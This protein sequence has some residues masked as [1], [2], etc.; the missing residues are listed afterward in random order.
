[1][2]EKLTSLEDIIT[3]NKQE[4]ENEEQINNISYNEFINDKIKNNENLEMEINKEEL[5]KELE[6]KVENGNDYKETINSY[7]NDNDK[8]TIKDLKEKLNPNI[9]ENEIDEIKNEEKNENEKENE[10]KKIEEKKENELKF[11]EKKL[12]TILNKKK[13]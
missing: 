5:I 7:F 13:K 3:P 6:E 1:M 2:S 4:K 10:E 8:M 11:E 12:E 9:K